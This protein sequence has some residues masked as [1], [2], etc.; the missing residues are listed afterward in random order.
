MVVKLRRNG[1]ENIFGV[2]HPGFQPFCGVC[3]C[4]TVV[5]F[6]SWRAE[7]LS[8]SATPCLEQGYSCLNLK[9][10]YGLSTLQ[11]LD[12]ASWPPGGHLKID[13]LR[14]NQVLPERNSILEGKVRRNDGQWP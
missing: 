9:E 11:W 12:L 2:N 4:I 8:L 6:Q 7:T 1:R 10:K 14:K 13:L 5:G 3:R